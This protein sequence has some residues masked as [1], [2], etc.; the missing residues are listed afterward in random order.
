MHQYY[1]YTGFY[2]FLGSSLLKAIPLILLFIG[3]LFAIHFFV[4]DVNVLLNKITETFPAFGVF[5]VFFISESV[6]GL[7]PPELFIAWSSKS[8]TPVLHLSLLALLSYAGGVVSFYIGKAITKI[9][10]IHDYLEIK[11]A[12]HIRNTRKWG[13]FLIVVGALLPIPF[14]ITT[15]AAGIIKYP[16]NSLL[17]FGLLR[18]LRFY[19]YAL[20]IFNIVS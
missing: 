19:L 3:G 7:I 6:L 13:G 1:S 20:A 11:M 10:S 14:S 18:F 15:M 12:K 2:G 17:L 16:L 5:T 8:A 4:I 9:P